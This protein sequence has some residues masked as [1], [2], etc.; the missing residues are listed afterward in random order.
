MRPQSL[1][2]QES[3]N[4]NMIPS[5]V[6]EV[7]TPN[8]LYWPK[9]NVEAYGMNLF[10]RETAVPSFTLVELWNAFI[11][12]GERSPPEPLSRSEIEDV[13]ESRKERERGESKHFSSAEDLF[14]WL[15]SE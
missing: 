10:T 11:Q 9:S 7:S 5:Q 3:V 4:Y 1:L 8:A 15:D 14:A 6:E 13:V 12:Q 2:T